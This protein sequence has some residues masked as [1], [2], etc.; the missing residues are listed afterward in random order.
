MATLPD[1]PVNTALTLGAIAVVGLIGYTQKLRTTLSSQTLENYR[2]AKVVD[3]E[4]QAG[5]PVTLHTEKSAT[6]S[7]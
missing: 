4:L 2:H 6:R 3:A 7:A 5:T 1:T